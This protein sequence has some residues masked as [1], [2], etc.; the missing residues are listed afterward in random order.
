MGKKELGKRLF[1]A[2]P[3]MFPSSFSNYYYFGSNH[4]LKK[5]KSALWKNSEN[6]KLL[7]FCGIFEECP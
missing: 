2:D 7:N 1:L 4:T 3:K 5:G 6:L